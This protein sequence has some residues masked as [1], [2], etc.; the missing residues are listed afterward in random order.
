VLI[1]TVLNLLDRIS[2]GSSNPEEPSVKPGLKPIERTM[3]ET[4]EG[5]EEQ[6]S[7][8]ANPEVTAP[9]PQVNQLIVEN[10]D[11]HFV[12]SDTARIDGATLAQWEELYGKKKIEQIEIETFAGQ[13]VTCKIKPMKNS[14]YE[15]KGLVQLPEKIQKSLEVKKGELVR[16]KPV[17]ALEA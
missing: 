7:L 17:V 12:P 15:G 11:G 16:V 8:T 13:T 4:P 5:N 10:V 3:V 14:K 1:R 6:T 2:P 9:E